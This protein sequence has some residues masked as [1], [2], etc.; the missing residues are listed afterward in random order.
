MH[1]E[2]M[3]VY[4]EV[5]DNLSKS[6]LERL[7]GSNAE[8][9]LKF[10][11]MKQSLNAKIKVSQKSIERLESRVHDLTQFDEPMQPQSLTYN[12][13]P[14]NS[15]PTSASTSS[16]NFESVSKPSA[17]DDGFAV[18]DFDEFDMMVSR[19]NDFE[20]SVVD[21]TPNATDFPC[22]PFTT[23]TT[24]QPNSTSQQSQ[25]SNHSHLGRYNGKIRYYL[26]F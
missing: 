21:L 14:M 16:F 11:V 4:C 6:E 9:L 22:S 18:D 20:G 5:F 2:F 23:T 17:S 25:N 7:F 15:F 8:K 3:A 13:T 10:K 19:S 24:S 26:C 12:H 1:N